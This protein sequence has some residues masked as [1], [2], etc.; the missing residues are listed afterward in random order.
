MWG[1]LTQVPLL[2]FHQWCSKTTCL[3]CESA[4]EYNTSHYLFVWLLGD[5]L[6]LQMLL[7]YSWKPIGLKPSSDRC[8]TIQHLEFDPAG[9]Q[10]KEC[11]VDQ[12]H[13]DHQH[14]KEC[15]Q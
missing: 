6:C 14:T 2:F 3:H 12:C 8:S 5:S 13:D 7:T 9:P 4:M 15:V 1:F 10:K 11:L